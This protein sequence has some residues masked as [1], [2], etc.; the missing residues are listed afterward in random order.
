MENPKIVNNDNTVEEIKKQKNRKLF[1]QVLVG[2]CLGI[3]IF[4]FSKNGFS[5][6]T[7]FPLILAV[8]FIKGSIKSAK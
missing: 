1:N 4:S 3:S 8:F 6:P 7:F 2:I 5:W